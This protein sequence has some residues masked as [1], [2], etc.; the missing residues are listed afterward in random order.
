LQDLLCS[1]SLLRYPDYIKPFVE[2][3]DAI[4]GI[5]SHGTIGNDLPIAYTFQILNKLKQNY[6]TLEKTLLIVYNVQ[7]FRLYIYDRK[8]TLVTDHQLLKWL[9]SVKYP[10]SRLVLWRLKLAEYEYKVNYKVGKANTNADALSRKVTPVLSHKVSE[11]TDFNEPLS[12]RK[13][14]RKR[15]RRSGSM[16]DNGSEE[17]QL[18]INT[19]PTKTNN[20]NENER[21]APSS[22]NVKRNNMENLIIYPYSSFIERLQRI[23]IIA[24]AKAKTKVSLRNP[25]SIKLNRHT[26]LMQTIYS[27]SVTVSLHE[28][29]TL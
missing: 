29:I 19:Q 28:K 11:K 27:K 10:R 14:P 17:M 3:M 20:N 21:D 13:S 1:E 2:I 5:L 7:F 8:F 22:K 15:F 12:H 23:N 26:I 4:A 18:D 25:A 16:T 24:K 6:S 9:H